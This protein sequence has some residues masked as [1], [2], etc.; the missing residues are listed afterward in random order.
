MPWMEATPMSL[1]KE[2]AT[3]ASQARS[4]IS[5]LCRRFMIS[6][7]T[8]Y[9]WLG[10]FLEQGEEGM[11]NRSRRP[12]SSPFKTDDAVAQAVLSVRD[13]HPAWGGRKIRWTL[14]EQGYIEVPVPSTITEILRRNGR[15]SP[16]EAQKHQP[17][18]RFEYEAPNELW[19]MDFK[20][21]FLIRTRRCYPLTVLDDHSRFSL[22]L[23]ACSD[24]R[25]E[26]V[27][28]HLVMAFERYGLPYRIL[29]DNGTP[30]VS[31]ERYTPLSV[32]LIRLGIDVC[33]GRVRHPQT[34]GKE[35]RFHRTL[36]AE[37]IST[38][39]FAD[40]GDC[41]RHLSS[42]RDVYNCERPHEGLAMATP[43]SQYT[44]SLRSYPSS[45]P[46]I[47]YGPQDFVRKVQHGGVIYFKGKE[48]WVGKAFLG[49]PVGV[50]PTLMDG[51]YDVYFCHHKIA[52]IDQTSST[53][54]PKNV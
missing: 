50:R 12:S 38:R 18:Q 20:G 42:W 44:I 47:E 2:F 9:K 51:L 54:E 30:W 45:L 35:E 22:L 33:H 10:R 37:L 53:T 3:L 34:I 26:T 1:R 8:G 6:R 27:Q 14:L 41:Q 39:S 40:F 36:Q 7:P 49:H 23:E 52:S 48:H 15:L 29:T 31:T 19:Q 43:A 5:Q 13:K 28:G 21:D 24:R 17:C 16:Q 4:N 11:K 25:T 32:W 46:P